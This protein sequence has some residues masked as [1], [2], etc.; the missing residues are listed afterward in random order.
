MRG[1]EPALLMLSAALALYGAWRFANAGAI[2]RY[3]AAFDIALAAAT[4]GLI[5]FWKPE[6]GDGSG[7]APAA[8]PSLLRDFVVYA[9]PAVAIVGSVVYVFTR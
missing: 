4:Y 8:P 3:P 2:D 6:A 1:L 5:V 7:V 9:V